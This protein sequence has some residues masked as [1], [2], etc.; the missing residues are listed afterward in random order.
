MP[1]SPAAPPTTTSPVD[2]AV[3]ALLHLPPGAEE[4]AALRTAVALHARGETRR[5]F[6]PMLH[7]GVPG[8]GP[9]QEVVLG[10]ADGGRLDHAL[11]TDLVEAVLRRTARPPTQAPTQAPA[12]WPLLWLTRPGTL[13]L[14]D[15]DLAWSAA[16]AA[17]R[18]ETGLA[19]RFVIVTRHGWRDP[20][21]GARRQW[22]RIRG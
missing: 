12:R 17:A 5:R 6:A 1:H 19:H 16:A 8:G 2:P 20:V 7:A 4:L 3:R 22:R 18:E 21:S 15:V 14:E 9:G 10:L 13:D 11:R